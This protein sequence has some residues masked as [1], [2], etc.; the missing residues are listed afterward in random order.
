MVQYVV[1][2]VRF[3]S[4]NLH[5]FLNF[6]L[7]LSHVQSIYVMGTARTSTNVHVQ[8]DVLPTLLAGVVEFCLVCRVC[9][10]CCCSSFWSVC[11]FFV[12][13][14]VVHVFFSF[15]SCSCLRGKEEGTLFVS[16]VVAGL[17]FV[18]LFALCV[19]LVKNL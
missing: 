10:L 1:P 8:A 15:S 14:Y 17:Q 7:I 11:F 12:S 3:T 9:G 4:Q 16:V 2:G 6:Q 5:F 18:V 13:P 19:P